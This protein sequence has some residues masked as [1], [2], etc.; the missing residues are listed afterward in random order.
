MSKLA[1][2]IKSPRVIV[3]IIFLVLALA[4]I[5]PAMWS[6]GAA[7]RVVDKDSPAQLA[8][9]PSP[10]PG[11]PMS[12][13]VIISVNNVPIKNAQEYYDY[14]STLSPNVTI[15]VKTNQEIYKIR[16]EQRFEIIELNETT[17]ETITVEQ[18]NETKTITTPKTEKITT[19]GA[20]IGIKVF[21]APKTNVRKGLDLQGGTRVLLA[22][23]ER[24][25]QER[26]GRGLTRGPA[27]E[28]T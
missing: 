23:E 6:E 26:E 18:T 2:I 21:D 25:S 14:V 9:I 10:R 4:A 20:Y 12:K 13:E 28:R 15:Q 27:R 17:T 7:I 22:P 3:L 11:S 8:G 1:R 24:E 16:T 19:Q 5:R